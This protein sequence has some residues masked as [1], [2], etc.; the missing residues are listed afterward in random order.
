M[1]LSTALPHTATP[2]LSSEYRVGE[3]TPKI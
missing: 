2:E 3:E 1:R